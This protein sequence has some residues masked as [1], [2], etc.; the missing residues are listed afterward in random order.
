MG[1]CMR[2]KDFAVGDV[3]RDTYICSFHLIGNF[4]PTEEY[5]DPILAT[6]TGDANR[7]CPQANP[8]SLYV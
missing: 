7:L 8:K 4:S 1:S 6:W 2:Q 5:P 3:K